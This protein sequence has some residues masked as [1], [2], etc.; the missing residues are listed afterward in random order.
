MGVAKH[1]KNSA[2]AKQC[3]KYAA[4]NRYEKN[5]ARKAERHKKRLAR[6]AARRAAKQAA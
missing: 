4:E 1:G 5:K 6:F 3:A 2:H